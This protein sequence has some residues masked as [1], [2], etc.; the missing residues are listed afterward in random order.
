MTQHDNL[1]KGE[2][3]PGIGYSPNLNPSNLA[4]VI[5]EYA[6][7]DASHVDAAVSSSQGGLP[8]LVHRRHPGPRRC[9]GQD[10]HRESS[11]ARKSSARCWP[12]RK[13]RPNP[14]A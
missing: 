11:P 6:Q 10:R 1:I 3:V 8:G 14:R 13:A 9:A 5:G 12:A 7:G 4:D 2:W